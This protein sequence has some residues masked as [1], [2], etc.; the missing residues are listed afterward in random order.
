[1]EFPRFVYRAEGPFEMPN[2][3]FDARIA[4]DG[5]EF[6]QALSEGWHETLPSAIANLGNPSPTKT[7]EIFTNKARAH[8]RRSAK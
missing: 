5:F 1:M 3:T 4:A 2:G 8:N 7:P 6:T